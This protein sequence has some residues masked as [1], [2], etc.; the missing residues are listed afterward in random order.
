MS[1]TACRSLSECARPWCEVVLCCRS[2]RDEVGDVTASSSPKS[3]SSEMLASALREMG[4][5]SVVSILTDIISR[6]SLT[7]LVVSVTSHFFPI[8]SVNVFFTGFLVL[9]RRFL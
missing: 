7:N 3:S 8:L 4:V 9:W 5:E 2:I 1:A 6:R